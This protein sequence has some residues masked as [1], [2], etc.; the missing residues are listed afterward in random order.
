MKLEGVKGEYSDRILGRVVI[1][2]R[3]RFLFFFVKFELF[4]VEV[5][6]KK[7]LLVPI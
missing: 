3:E 2:T 5:L 4:L 7:L 1:F 6:V